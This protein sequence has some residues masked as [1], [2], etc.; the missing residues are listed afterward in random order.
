M[1]MNESMTSI[2]VFHNDDYFAYLIELVFPN[3][4][5]RTDYLYLLQ[6]LHTYD[7]HPSLERDVNRVF[8]ALQLREAV[9]DRL[10]NV[11][12]LNDRCCTMLEM[13]AALAN[14]IEDTIMYD[15][16]YGNRISIWFKEMLFSLGLLDMNNYNFNSE[17]VDHCINRFN[18]RMY[19][20]NGYGSLFTVNDPN[21]D[22]RDYEIWYQMQ[23]YISEY[24]KISEMTE[25]V[26]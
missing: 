12:Q 25:L 2:R 17:Y 22:M 18:N 9:K 10:I 19:Q 26:Y 20:K 14:R 7:Y 5:E 15:P 13:M 21:I 16:E 23:A 1:L 11:S 4:Q 24:D 8:D 6:T 3:E